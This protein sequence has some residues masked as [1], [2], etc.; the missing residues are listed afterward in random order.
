MSMS[1]PNRGWALETI[2]YNLGALQGLHATFTSL[3]EAG[4]DNQVVLRNVESGLEGRGQAIAR[5][6][7]DAGAAAR[8]IDPTLEVARR[9]SQTV[10]AYGEAVDRHA[11]AANDLVDDVLSAQARMARAAETLSEARQ[12]RDA[13]ESDM[14]GGGAI[15]AQ[16]AVSDAKDDHAAEK[17]ALDDLWERWEAAYGFW[18]DAYGEA[19]GR[20][21]LV[22][23][24]SAPRGLRSE[25]DDLA[26]AD[27]PAEVAAI[28][29]S[30]T[31]DEQQRLREGLPGFI[32]NL[33]GIPYGDRML[34]NRAEFER[35]VAAGPY[36]EPLDGELS[37]LAEEVKR[38][39]QMLAFRPFE[40]PQ[41]TAAVV[42]GV[43]VVMDEEGRVID[44]LSGVSNVSVLVGGMFS[45]LR[46]LKEWGK[47]ARGLN[48]ASQIYGSEKSVT[49]A[50][51]G[52]DSPDLV[53]EAGMKQA[54]E[55]AATLTSML[56]GLAQAS[57]SAATTTVI[58]HSYGSTT[59]F[60]AVGT[61]EEG[62]GVDRLVAVGSAGVPTGLYLAGREQG[63]ERSFTDP[64]PQLNF[65]GVDI[66]ASRAPGDLVGWFG[67]LTSM[68]HTESPESYPGATT[69]DSD[70][71][72]VP[73]LDDPS[74][75][76]WAVA[77]PGHAA[78]D[79]ANIPVL[80]SGEKDNGYLA[81]NSESL[82]N[83]ANIVAK[84]EPIN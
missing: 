39:G 47:S 79:G 15:E 40:S 74:R 82:R 8:E 66:Y 7:D 35:V 51:Y 68:G 16:H 4:A 76:E 61:A 78:H 22:L 59:A 32:G 29:H 6:K 23:A 84:G 37:D 57:P 46:D 14:D 2:E 71:G 18:N 75:K 34:A 9:I 52:Y 56:R 13:A 31:V 10:R 72:W 69:F 3:I 58:G 11:R 5:A 73:S 42:Y 36:G 53:S 49:I 26:N 83:L 41:A 50:W 38:G 20:L 45:G 62:L 67:Q 27:S 54:E 55:G 81:R 1:S 33:E 70:G 63:P 30:L 64:F 43:D 80:Q 65:A 17:A 12:S 77:T 19:V 60:L 24:G 21:A 28:W 44:P 25:V 48:D